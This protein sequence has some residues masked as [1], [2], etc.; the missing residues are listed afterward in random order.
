[1][2]YTLTI[3]APRDVYRLHMCLDSRLVA[4]KRKYYYYCTYRRL[5]GRRVIAEEEVPEINGA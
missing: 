4:E 5:R 1:M 2:L 3:I